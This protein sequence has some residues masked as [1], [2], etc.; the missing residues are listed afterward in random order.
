MERVNSRLDTSLGFEQHAIRGIRK[1]TMSYS[2]A[3]ILMLTLALGR[4]RQKK[5][6][7]LRSWF[8]QLKELDVAAEQDKIARGV[9]LGTINVA[10]S[11]L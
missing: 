4:V 6:E 8:G 3:P 5:L 7:L 11:D 10:E 1:M 2:L 9:C